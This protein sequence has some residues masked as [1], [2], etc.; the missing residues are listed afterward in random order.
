MA[1]KLKVVVIGSGAAGLSCARTLGRA[2]HEVTMV[3][4]DRLGGTCMWRGCIPKK[5]LFHTGEV[6]RTVAG[7][8]QFGVLTQGAHVDWQG[9]LAWK[10]H[11]QETYAGDQ[12]GLAEAA[13]VRVI[14]ADARFAAEDAVEVAGERIAFDHAV[15]ATGSHAVR[16]PILGAQLAD[17]SDDALRY[18]ELPSS[19]IIVGGGFIAMEMAGIF[20]S[21]GTTVTVLVRDERPLEMLDDEL[22]R[23]ATHGLESLG[24]RVVTSTTVTAIT[25]EAGGLRVAVTDG[26]GHVGALSAERVLLATGRV[27]TLEDLGLDAAAVA[28]DQGGRLVLDEYS[29]TTNPRVWAVGD[30]AGGMMQ[31][32][33]ASLEGRAVAAS[34]DSG[35]PV[36]ADCRNVP[37]TCFTVPPVATV[38]LS[39]AA[40]QA[41]G[42]D[43]HV[44]R[45]GF[46]ELGQAVVEAETGG[47]FK[48]ITAAESDVVIGAQCAGPAAA[49]MIY[50]AAVAMIGGVTAPQLVRLV[51][52]HPS[53]AEAMH[54]AGW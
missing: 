4:R 39:E 53:Y 13:G 45:V 11:V 19:L 17:T 9:A 22:A 18:P 27:P 12:R 3:E 28:V 32:P 36:H 37:V 26:A 6:M 25:S 10:W 33:V 54:Y 51:A 31:T 8:E 49:D 47:V 1:E 20:A 40:A 30:A 29:R 14:E 43:A 38:G 5:S 52:V 48:L 16:P 7:A 23:I 21:L 41:K 44:H 24:A 35:S 42:I 2:G 50:A 15:I 34:I 46:D